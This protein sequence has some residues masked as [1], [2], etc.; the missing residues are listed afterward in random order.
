MPRG[1]HAPI[2]PSHLA[3]VFAFLVAKARKVAGK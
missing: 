3:A 2:H 1:S